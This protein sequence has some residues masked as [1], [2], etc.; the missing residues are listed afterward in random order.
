MLSFNLFSLIKIYLFYG[1]MMKNI[2]YVYWQLIL[3][4]GY[5]F[6]TFQYRVKENVPYRKTANK[7][8]L[9]INMKKRLT[10]F[11]FIFFSILAVGCWW[12][13]I[14]FIFVV[15]QVTV[16]EFSLREGRIRARYKKDDC[17]FKEE[18]FGS[19]LEH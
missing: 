9:S 5:Y 13:S 19:W 17:R 15:W 6:K 1:C 8:A 14:E 11:L 4:V 18:L 3:Q 10:C 12:R 16:T 2:N 7:A